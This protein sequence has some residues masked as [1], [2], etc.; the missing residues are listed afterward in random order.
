MCMC[1]SNVGNDQDYAQ[2]H[3]VYVCMCMYVLMYVYVY[4]Y[5][6]V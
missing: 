1:M 5:V 3:N 4:V 6:H 2:I